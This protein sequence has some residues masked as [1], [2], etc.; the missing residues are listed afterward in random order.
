MF[1]LSVWFASTALK[2]CMFMS[3]RLMWCWPQITTIHILLCCSI[4]HLS[5]VEK[6]IVDIFSCILN[7][8]FWNA[9]SKIY[10]SMLFLVVLLNEKCVNVNIISN[11]GL[12][13]WLSSVRKMESWQLQSVLG[14]DS[15]RRFQKA[16]GHLPSI[17]F[18]AEYER[19]SCKCHV[20]LL[21]F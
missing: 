9:I 4:L 15:G 12:A 17:S 19:S 7:A 21:I 10:F 18:F 16:P 6:P 3:C 14:N 8:S 1:W 2:Y 5:A 20:H 11:L 13:F